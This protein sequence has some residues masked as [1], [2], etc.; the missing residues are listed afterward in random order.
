MH[1]LTVQIEGTAEAA[2]KKSTLGKK[3]SFTTQSYHV[4][5]SI[6]FSGKAE[7]YEN[8]VLPIFFYCTCQEIVNWTKACR[9][10]RTF[11]ITRE[12]IKKEYVT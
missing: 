1:L 10:I 11:F 12:N 4:Q 5:I 3:I 9:Y 6:N 8:T 7:R 2:L